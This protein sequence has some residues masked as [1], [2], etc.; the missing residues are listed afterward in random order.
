MKR[1]LVATVV[2]AG[3]A[4]AQEEKKQDGLAAA[5]EAVT[6]ALMATTGGVEVAGESA[7]EMPEMFGAFGG[8][9]GAGKIT[10][11]VAGG[12]FRATL[13]S[14]GKGST[15]EV[16]HKDGKT[17]ERLTWRGKKGLMGM[18]FMGMGGGA[19][20]LLSLLD[21]NALTKAVGKAKEGKELAAQ[22]V[23]DAECKVYQVVLAG[24]TIRTYAEKDEDEDEEGPGGVVIEGMGGEPSKVEL[25]MWVNGDG[26]IVKLEGK[27]H[28]SFGI[29]IQGFGGGDDE[30]EDEEEGD[31]ESEFTTTYTF[32]LSKHGEAKVEIPADVLK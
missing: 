28:R 11:A 18:G 26:R 16:F 2:M 7:V 23:G 4:L 31:E 12:P 5:K 10:G 20:D 3:L 1:V 19:D 15:Y 9:G 17:V 30:D 27:V 21:F 24:D 14:Q 32:T 22:K 13:K 6:K 25:K 8:G 29:G